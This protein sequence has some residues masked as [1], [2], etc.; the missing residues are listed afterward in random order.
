MATLLDSF[1]V[2]LDSKADTSGFDIFGAASRRLVVTLGDVMNIVGKITGGISDVFNNAVKADVINAKIEGLGESADYVRKQVYEMSQGLG[3]DFASAI[4]NYAKLKQYGVDPLAGSL[5]QLKSIGM[6]YGSDMNRLILAFGQIKAMGTLQGQEKNQLINAGI[7]IWQML[8]NTTGKS[9]GELQ[10]MMKNK[11]ITFDMVSQAFAAE[12]KRLEPT[13]E[14][15]SH[16]VSAQ[17][18]KMKNWWFQTQ[19]AISQTRLWSRASSFLEQWVNKFINYFTDQRVLNALNQFGDYIFNTVQNI[20][21]LYHAVSTNLPAMAAIIAFVLNQ[22]VKAWGAAMVAMARSGLMLLLNPLTWIVAG[23]G[24]LL[25]ALIDIDDAVNGK[26]SFINWGEGVKT[27][28]KWFRDFTIGVAEWLG[29]KEGW[30]SMGDSIAKIFDQVATA[31]NG[32]V[33]KVQALINTIKPPAW[34]K[35][36]MDYFGLTTEN[37]T[38]GS[39]IQ[40]DIPMGNDPWASTRGAASEANKKAHVNDLQDLLSKPWLIPGDAYNYLNNGLNSMMLPFVMRGR[41]AQEAANNPTAPTVTNNNVTVTSTINTP[42]DPNAVA[43]AVK[44]EVVNGVKQANN[45]NAN[46]QA[47][48]QGAVKQ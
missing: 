21:D 43:G 25:A 23:L 39:N 18:T 33:A 48:T 14:K 45:A 4:D 42:A 13:I 17:L 28:Y 1:L 24:L 10:D 19:Q 27:A 6:V 32:F 5:K 38:Q 41:A 35:S 34:V 11:Q 15:L 20:E 37:T 44:T 9:I 47:N 7:P 8:V 31:F 46:V 30:K 36:L 16:S 26:K 12:Q 29:D 22:V 3:T 2:T 40:P